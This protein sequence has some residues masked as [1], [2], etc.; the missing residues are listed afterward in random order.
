MGVEHLR[1]SEIGFGVCDSGDGVP[2]SCLG[3]GTM[4]G[5]TGPVTG[6]SRFAV[7]DYASWGCYFD[8]RWRLFW[9]LIRA[10]L[11]NRWVVLLGMQFAPTFQ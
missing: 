3:G 5:Q 8:L 7:V 11:V 6:G 9:T 4:V 2:P 1:R 10:I